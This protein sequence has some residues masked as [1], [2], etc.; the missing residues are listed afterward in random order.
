VAKVGLDGVFQEV[1]PDEHLIELVNRAGGRFPTSA[2][3]LNSDQFGRV[4]LAWWKRTAAW[5]GLARP[6]SPKE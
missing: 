6:K 3:S 1:R 2:I 4:T 5:S